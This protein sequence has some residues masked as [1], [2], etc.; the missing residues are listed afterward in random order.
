MKGEKK[1]GLVE[2]TLNTADKDDF[3]IIPKGCL[4]Y[5][6]LLERSKLV[7][8]L[9]GYETLQNCCLDEVCLALVFSN[10]KLILSNFVIIILRNI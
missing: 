7:S 8:L 1:L 4:L 5:V 2:I 6:M 3:E 9:V 10:F